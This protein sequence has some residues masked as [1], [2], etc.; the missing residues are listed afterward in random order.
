MEQPLAKVLITRPIQQEAINRIAKLYEVRV[1]PIDAPMP[2]ELL[3][4]AMNDV[5]G[6]M[7]S[8]VRI[9]EKLIA[10]APNLRVVANIGVG[11]DNIDVKACSKR[12]V[13]VTNT[14]DV[15]TEA[16]ADLTF[17][18]ML[19]AAKAIAMFVASSGCSGSGTS[20]WAPKYMARHWAFMVL[21]GLREQW[22]AALA[23]SRCASCITHVIAHLT[24]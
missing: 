21:A 10:L 24:I 2:E 6:V 8:A 22:R 11:Y 9:T 23:A 14:P 4:E 13:M 19:S 16:T 20:C 15:L 18:L 12:G 3:A 1:H 17:A 7:P 5:A